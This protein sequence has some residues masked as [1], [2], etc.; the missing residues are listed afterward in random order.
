MLFTKKFHRNSNSKWKKLIFSSFM[1][2]FPRCFSPIIN[3]KFYDGLH[4]NWKFIFSVFFMKYLLMFL[5]FLFFSS[6][7]FHRSFSFIWND[8][9]KFSSFN[10]I[11][12]SVV[13]WEILWKNWW[14]IVENMVF[15]VWRFFFVSFEIELYLNNYSFV[16]KLYLK[17][18]MSF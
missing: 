11:F 8:R 1:Y 15:D 10:T 18:P 7:F 12:D 2:F 16:Q 3:S 14:K 5:D 4:K 6:A 9:K 17:N 13:G